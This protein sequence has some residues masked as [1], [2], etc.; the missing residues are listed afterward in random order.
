VTSSTLQ[1]ASLA[2][3]GLAV[4]AGVGGLF[5]SF[6][7]LTSRQALDVEAGVAGLIAGAVL[8]GSGTVSL[9]ILASRG[10]DVPSGPPSR[11]TTVG[12]PR[13]DEWRM[14]SAR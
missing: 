6:G 4:V 10:A 7:Y 2:L 14:M 8:V 11:N 9:A 13:D 12:L 3:A 1:L 5:L